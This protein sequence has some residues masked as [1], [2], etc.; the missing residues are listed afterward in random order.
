MDQ[1]AQGGKLYSRLVGDFKEAQRS[2]PDAKIAAM[3]WHQGESDSDTVEVAEAYQAKFIEFIQAV[4][5]EIQEPDLLFIYGQINPG[6]FFCGRPRFLHADIVRKA[7]A[8]LTLRNTLMIT[9]DD[10]EKNAYVAGAARTREDQRIAK[11]KD[12]VHYSATGQIKL[13]N[14]FAVT[15]LKIV[16]LLNAPYVMPPF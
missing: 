6:P 12:D 9:T 1:W 5:N 8:E 16:K 7:Q 10:C 14:R 4:R 3:L 2:V 11:N 13:G 15:Y